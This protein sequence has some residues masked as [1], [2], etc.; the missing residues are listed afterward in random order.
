MGSADASP[1]FVD[2]FLRRLASNLCKKLNRFLIREDNSGQIHYDHDETSVEMFAAK[3]SGKSQNPPTR[4]P[5]AGE[6]PER[7]AKNRLW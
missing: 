4:I 6:D 5:N 2:S 1:S 3:E 7:L